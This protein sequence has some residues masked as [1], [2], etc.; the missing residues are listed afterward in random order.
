MDYDDEGKYMKEL[1]AKII[2]ITIFVSVIQLFAEE[3]A[4]NQLERFLR[5][6]L[7]TIILTTV[8]LYV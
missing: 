5:F 7:A 2:Y 8:L 6:V 3:D 4:A 1:L